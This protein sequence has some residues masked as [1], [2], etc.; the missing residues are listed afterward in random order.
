VD[1]R[2]GTSRSPCRVKPWALRCGRRLTRRERRLAEL[3][4]RGLSNAEIAER[5]VVSV[6]T[7]ESHLFRAMQKLGVSDRRE[8]ASLIDSA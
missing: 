8:I 5:L 3:A 7:V 1:A 2:D 6:R 4:G